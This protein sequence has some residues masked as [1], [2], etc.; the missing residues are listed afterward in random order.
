MTRSPSTERTAGEAVTVA[1][2]DGG[3]V[4]L[5][6]LARLLDRTGE[7]DLVPVDRFDRAADGEIRAAGRGTRFAAT[8]TWRPA[9]V[10]GADR[11]DVT[12]EIACV[13]EAAV[14]AGVFVAVLLDPADDPGWLVPGLFY[15]ENRVAGCRRRY[16]RFV[17]TAEPTDDLASSHWSFRSDRAA[18]PSVSAR[19]GRIGATL[20]TRERSPLGPTG[21]GFASHDDATGVHLAFPWREE[22]VVYDGSETARPAEILLHPWQP[23][24]RVA[25]ELRLY[26][27]GPEPRHRAPVQRDLHAWLA[28]G[29]PLSPWVPIGEAARLAAHGLLAWHYRPEQAVLH[30]TA[31]FERQGDGSDDEPTD[32]RAMHVAWL[33]GTPAAYALL[34]HGRRVRDERAAEAGSRVLD[35]I[36][37]NLAPCGTFWGQWTA[38]DGWGKGWTPGE[39]RLHARTLGEAATFMLR[40]LRHVDPASPRSSTWRDA[41]AANLAF[42]AARQRDDGALPA[43][44][45]GTTGAVESWEGSAALAWVPPLAEGARALGQP[46]LLDTARRAGTFHASQVEAGFLFG[47]PEDVDLAPTSEDGYVALMAYVALAD[48]ETDPAARDGWVDLARAAADWMLTF[49]YTYNV[50]FE[51]TTLLGRYDF[52]SRGA[53]NASPANQHLHAYGLICTPELVRLAELTGD[54]WYRDRARETLACFRQFIARG[55][56]DFNARRGMA[57]ERYYQTNCF[58][59]KGAIGPL[60][61]AWSLALLLYACD[62]AADLPGLTEAS[63]GA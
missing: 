48:A 13:A 2:A 61:H 8:A 46:A 20:A 54:P 23:G 9:P 45:H 7:V 56:G 43:Q 31:A 36:A 24:E 5:P 27:H 26:V 21:V 32:R 18:T 37:G 16:P 60:S 4:R 57:P 34:A 52:R 12:L 35:A 47:A 39:D 30:E 10:A 53:D 55:D 15:G 3:A 58:G 51:P 49:R 17:R 40:A 59:P 25:L 14:E 44:W 41:V 50:D 42:V 29:A 63:D 19:D 33:S 1:T 38:A 6:Y 28:A 62:A 11:W 22:P